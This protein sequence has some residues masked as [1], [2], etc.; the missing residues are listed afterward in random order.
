MLRV[1]DDHS[2][3]ASEAYISVLRKR[4]N[5]E[6]TYSYGVEDC[7]RSSS[8][9]ARL[10]AWRVDKE[11]PVTAKTLYRWVDI[12]V[13]CYL[14]PPSLRRIPDK[15]ISPAIE[16]DIFTCGR[17]F[18]KTISRMEPERFLNNFRD[19]ARDGDESFADEA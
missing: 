4:D 1:Q 17:L 13:T 5:K 7:T 16:L 10:P 9:G 2:S 18:S 19:E 12:A 14:D 3:R 11:L 15:L 6:E 8:V